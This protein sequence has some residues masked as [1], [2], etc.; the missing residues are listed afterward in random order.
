MSPPQGQA[1]Q[2]WQAVSIVTD[3]QCPTR[4]QMGPSQFEYAA[5]GPGGVIRG[6]LC[7]CF[8]PQFW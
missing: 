1:G 8:C 6:A 3:Q 2:A 5:D 4:Q 7:T